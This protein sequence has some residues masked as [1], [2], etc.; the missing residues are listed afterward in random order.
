MLIATAISLATSS[1]CFA[2]D[3]A[4][5]E[6][7]AL[8]YWQ[9]FAMIPADAHQHYGALLEALED[10][11]ASDPQ[12]IKLVKSS[13]NALKL[14]HRGSRIPHCDWGIAYEDGIAAL[15]PH[16]MKLRQLSRIACLRAMHKFERMDVD[17]GIDDLIA[18][19]KMGRHACAD[20]LLIS[21]LVG[22]AIQNVAIQNLAYDTPQF[23]KMH[24]EK[25][26]KRL[27]DVTSFPSMKESI[28][29]EKK[30]MVDWLREKVTSGKI[31]ELIKHPDFQ[32]IFTKKQTQQQRLQMLASLQES[33]ETAAQYTTLHPDECEK[34]GTKFENELKK[35][36]AKH[37][38]ALILLP[39]CSGVRRNEAAHQ[40]KLAMLEA[41]IVVILKDKSVLA[42]KK[43][44]DPIEK[45]PFEIEEFDGGF[46][47]ISDLIHGKKPVSLT[48]GKLK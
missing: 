19:M 42:K 23:R 1:L 40:I 28:L 46:V 39:G 47:L 17:G 41:G 8:S 2:Q 7:A 18:V 25:L 34:K 37:P 36:P 3:D 15:L 38:L 35:T 31:E 30:I 10:R 44:H 26:Q 14:M 33:Y 5:R 27:A 48:F 11:D 6:N 12:L 9:A 32:G 13:E 4:L 45:Q 21:M 22:V 16:L 24:L 29:F 20:K 43:Y